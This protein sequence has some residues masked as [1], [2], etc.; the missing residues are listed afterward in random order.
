M[1]DTQP[2]PPQPDGIPNFDPADNNRSWEWVRTITALGLTVAAVQ[3]ECSLADLE[4]VG[5][6]FERRIGRALQAADLGHFDALKQ[7]RPFVLYFYLHT[8]RLPAALD[9]LK[10]E[11]EELGLI[12]LCKIT[13]ADNSRQ[14]WRDFY[15]SI[16]GFFE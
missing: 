2:T 5:L 16:P 15:P 4:R 12:H 6:G 13:H 9:L 7:G 3:V 11:L 1:R 10:G 8:V 14:V